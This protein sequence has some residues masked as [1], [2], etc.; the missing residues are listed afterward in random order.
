MPEHRW[1]QPHRLVLCSVLA[2]AF[3]LRCWHLTDPAWDYH[4]WRQTITLMVARD[5]SRH[6][7]LLH[8]TVLWLSNGAPVYFNAEFS[9]QSILAAILYRL[10]GES[11]AAAR[12]VV[13]AFSLAGIAWL[14]QLLHRRSSPLAA[15]LGA[16][17][18]AV[19]PYSLF[20]GRVFM[21][22]V[23]A[24]S[25]ALGGISMLDGWTDNRRTRDLIAASVLT[26]L[27]IL[28]KLTVA[29]VALPVLYLF[30]Q[31]Y[32]RKILLRRETYVFAAVALAPSLAWYRHAYHL[33]R[34]S[35]SAVMQ[36]GLFFNGL[37]RW[38]HPDFA[39]PLFKALALEAFS[40]L[41]LALVLTGFFWPASDRL[42]W[43]LRLWMIGAAGILGLMPNAL[44]ANHYYFTVLL[45]GGAGLMAL[46]LSRLT[47]DRRSFG[48][49]AIVMCVVIAGSLAST[50]PFFVPD[51][52]PFEMGRYLNRVTAPTDLI[53]TESGG[54]PNVLYYAD[55]RG[56]MLDRQ[57]DPAV[58]ERFCRAGAVWYADAFA[59]DA[60][61]HAAFFHLLDARFPRMSPPDAP[62][63]VYRLQQGP[64][65]VSRMK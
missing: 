29:F 12:L 36:P 14:Y 26:S 18:L 63:R 10:T 61:D 42:S 23:P 21:P 44:P 39:A 54:S 3:A 65:A 22:D 7:D 43:L 25:L 17:L 15:F 47:P 45:P 62:W 27:A 5:Y 64:S 11:D 32:G 20:F 34:N 40:P 52:L 41:A 46:A 28:Q 4:N 51:R 50:A 58:L 9:I 19:L 24:M 48:L 2:L 38:L 35:G 16:L 33:G 49:L 30:V 8:P 37:S 57:Y 59:S 1:A 60:A 31:V 6:F 55:R 13:I 56:W 53:V